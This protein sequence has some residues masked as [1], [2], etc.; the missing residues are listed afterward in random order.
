[1]LVESSGGWD[2]LRVINF[3][4]ILRIKIREGMNKPKTSV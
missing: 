4:F 3:S 1:M 2:V